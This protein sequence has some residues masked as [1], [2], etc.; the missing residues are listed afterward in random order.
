MARDPADNTSG[1]IRERT[2]LPS[3]NPSDPMGPLQ[4]CHQPTFPVSSAMTGLLLT[5]CVTLCKSLPFSL[6]PFPYL[7]NDGVGSGC[8]G[9]LTKSGTVRIKDSKLKR[10]QQRAR[11]HKDDYPLILS[12]LGRQIKEKLAYAGSN[13]RA[14]GGVLNLFPDLRFILSWTGLGDPP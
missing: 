2:A 14:W 9:C 11:A 6:L 13:V 8:N 10:G 3:Q 12:T 7:V 4:D 5:R 1:K